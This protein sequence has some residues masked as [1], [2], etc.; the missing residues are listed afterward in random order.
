M[1]TKRIIETRLRHKDEWF[2][3][4]AVAEVTRL[5]ILLIGP[6]GTGK[7]NTLL[8]YAAAKFNHDKEEASK[9]CFI[10]EVDEGT[11]AAEIRGRID[12]EK[13]VIDHKYDIHAPIVNANFVMINEVDKASSSFRN[14]MLSGMNEKELMTGKHR[15]K[16]NW[17]V[18]CASCNTI[19]SEEKDSPFWD[20]FVLKAK[21]DRLNKD[22][23]A[24]MMIATPSLHTDSK[25]LHSI[26]LNIPLQEDMDA[27]SMNKDMIKKFVSMTHGVLSDRTITYVPTI[28]KAIMHIY[29]MG[30]ASAF[31]KAA[32]ILCG[33]D[34]AS[35]L[36]KDIE[37]KELITIR[38]KAEKVTGISDG[39]TLQREVNLIKELIKNALDA[40]II[41]ESTSDSLIQNV[42]KAAEDNRYLDINFTTSK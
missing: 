23:L 31:V 27:I 5:P 13:L 36:S 21:V 3:L 25:A 9:H 12:I 28:V 11:K 33:T 39:A 32:E 42:R 18:W 17:E 4:L 26:E 37:P 40:G 35:K 14:S 6:P 16:L 20:R 7:T 22:Q 34:I 10:I 38:D 2:K 24:T 15:L 41:D 29:G 1:P 30:Q 8:D 19:P